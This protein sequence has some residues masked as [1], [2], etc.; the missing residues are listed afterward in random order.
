MRKMEWKMG[1]C[2]DEQ[3]SRRMGNQMRS[4][5]KELGMERDSECTGFEWKS[6]RKML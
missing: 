2:S 6:E 1:L 4:G 5:E 3:Q